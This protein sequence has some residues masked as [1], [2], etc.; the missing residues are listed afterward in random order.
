MEQ[1]LISAYSLENLSNARR[2]IAAGNI[3]GFAGKIDNIISI[4]GGSMES[5]IMSLMGR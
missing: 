2:E 4:F 5:E 1:V 3:N